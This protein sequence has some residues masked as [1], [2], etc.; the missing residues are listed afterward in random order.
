MVTIYWLCGVYLVLFIVTGVVEWLDRTR[1]GR[2]PPPDR[3][4]KRNGQISE[5]LYRNSFKNM[6][7]G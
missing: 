7:Q 1:E 3:S 2:L 6:R 4:V 5:E